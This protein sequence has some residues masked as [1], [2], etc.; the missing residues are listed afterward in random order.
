MGKFNTPTATA[1]TIGPIV[2][3]GP[4]ATFEGGAGFAR[5]AKSD[6]F[7]LAVT[8]MVGERT[9]Y[10][11][12]DARDARFEQLVHQVAVLDGDWMGRFIPWL[13]G[14][15]NMRSASLVAACEAVKA[16]LA[17]GLSGG[18]RCLIDAACQRADEPGEVLAYWTSRHGR[19]I[20][21]PVKRGLTD[22]V[23]R[24]YSGKSLLKY[25]TDSKG[26]RFGDV[27][28]LIHP[29]PHPDKPW[30]GELFKC[31]G[32]GVFVLRAE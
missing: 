32:H 27:L 14:E 1:R 19:T 6:L 29:A 16:R 13:R 12:A 10:E 24:L 2:T 26:Y 25:D 17:A 30:Q 7:L 4:A 20:P 5:D 23:R 15:A 28:N 8:N 18:N 31:R 22:A 11:N 21:M 9:F 3:T